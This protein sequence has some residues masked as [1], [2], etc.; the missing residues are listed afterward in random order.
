MTSAPPGT[1][2]GRAVAITAPDCAALRA[3]V[4]RVLPA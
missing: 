2:A 4:T 1:A 3:T